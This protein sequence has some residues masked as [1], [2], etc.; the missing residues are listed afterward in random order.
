MRSSAKSIALLMLPLILAA[1]GGSGAGTP[2]PIINPE[3][4]PQVAAPGPD[5]SGI[6]LPAPTGNSGQ[7]ETTASLG[8]PLPAVPQDDSKDPA[9]FT[10]G[11]HLVLGYDALDFS[12]CEIA[13]TAMVINPDGIAANNADN[14]PA[15]A[16]YRISGL[17][18]AAALSLNGG[19]LPRD[20]DMSYRVAVADYITLDWIWLGPTSFP[21]YQFDLAAGH[22]FIS[23]QG[24]LHFLVVCDGANT[25]VHYRSTVA[26]E[27]EEEPVPPPA[28]LYD[29]S[30]SVYGIYGLDPA[31]EVVEVVNDSG[32]S[33]SD[34]AGGEYSLLVRQLD[35]ETEDIANKEY[36]GGGIIAQPLAGVSVLLV[37]YDGAV[38]DSVATDDSGAF[39]FTGIEP[40][41]YLVTA[42]LADWMFQP[43][44]YPLSLPDQ[45][46]EA[47]TALQVD[48]L[49]WPA[50]LN[51]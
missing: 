22:Q 30:G 49:G 47:G 11:Q 26:L 38:Q 31:I 34:P 36:V 37:S 20:F 46:D 2:G 44:A 5:N 17:A 27:E 28:T 33:F 39:Q 50:D 42:Q 7:P 15:W 4:A 41:D 45:P 48:F 25:A 13:G 10:D 19:I 16:L 14:L 9:D 12:Q 8:R 18:D 43:S 24:N 1:C 21:E 6:S 35:T 51:P 40:G 32:N 29:L 3:P 23:D